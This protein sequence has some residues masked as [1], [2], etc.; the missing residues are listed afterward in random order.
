MAFLSRL[1]LWG[2][3]V[4]RFKAAQH[5]QGDCSRQETDMDGCRESLGVELF[6]GCWKGY[7]GKG[8]ME[9]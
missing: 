2:R 5:W 4:E 8:I 9:D 7:K 3:E 1:F 6:S